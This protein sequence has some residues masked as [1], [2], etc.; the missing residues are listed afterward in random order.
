MVYKENNYKE[1]MLK[2]ILQKYVLKNIVKEP[3]EIK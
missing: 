1:C 2:N 3:I